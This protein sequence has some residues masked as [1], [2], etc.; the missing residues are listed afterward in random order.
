MQ[1]EIWNLLVPIVFTLFNNIIYTQKGSFLHKLR[2]NEFGFHRLIETAEAEAVFAVSIR[3]L[4]PILMIS[5]S[6][7]SANSKPYSKRLYPINQG[8]GGIV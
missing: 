2:L 3:P 7:L 5:N 4:K 8:L 1:V 6:I